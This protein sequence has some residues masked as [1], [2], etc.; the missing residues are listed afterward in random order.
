MPAAGVTAILRAW[1]ARF[2]EDYLGSQTLFDPY[3]EALMNVSDSG[4]GR[5]I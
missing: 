3:P 4:K 5:E 2:D 1:I